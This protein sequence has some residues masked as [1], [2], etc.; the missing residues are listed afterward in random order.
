MKHNEYVK[1]IVIDV[2]GH[3]HVLNKTI[4]KCDNYEEEVLKIMNESFLPLVS[5]DWI[6]TCHIVRFWCR[7][8]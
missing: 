2:L 5:G 6:N 7:F 8:D 4:L 3:T 1:I